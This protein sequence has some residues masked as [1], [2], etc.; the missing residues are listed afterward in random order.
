VEGFCKII[1]KEVK[2]KKIFFLL[3]LLIC[4]SSVYSELN[5]IRLY[6]NTTYIS[7]VKTYKFNDRIYFDSSDI[8]NKM[9]GKTYWYPVSQKLIIQLKSHKIAIDKKNDYIKFDEEEEENLPNIIIVRAGKVFVSRDFF[10]SKLFSKTVGF[11]IESD[12]KENIIRMIDNV[13]ITSMRYFSYKEKTRFVIYLDVPLEF[14]TSQIEKKNFIISVINGSYSSMNEKISINDGVINT[15]EFEQED[16]SARFLVNLGEN[17]K[18]VEVFTLKEPDRIVVDFK[19]E[20]DKLFN[21]IGEEPV[22][23]I[24]PTASS[25]TVAMST[26]V[27]VLPDK[28][29]ISNGN[30]KKIVIDPGHGGK[31]PG[32]KIIFGMKEKDIN[33]NVARELYSLLKKEEKFDVILTRNKDEFIALNERSKIANDF[34]ADIFVSIHAN[35]SKNKGEKGFEVYFLSEKATDPWS[36]EV[37]DYENAV[38]SF[39]NNN[40]DYSP[41]A[42]LLHSLARNEYINEG[43]KIA[44]YISKEYEKNTSFVN[45]GIKQ[46]AFYVLRGTYA[47]GILIEMGFMTNSQDQKKLSDR[48]IHKKIAKA[49]YEGI[50][51]YAK[52]KGW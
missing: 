13:N 21:R 11:R 8:I 25:Q 17:F 38:I 36:A 35:A 9:G 4:I 45:R 30:V 46:A 24:L 43:S 2:M 19:A 40:F 6:K 3:S 33:L 41:A 23:L 32:G 47:P 52:S 50:L 7:K 22:N 29:G 14:K 20:E 34:G 49:I 44:G 5:E 27:A 51:K 48:K 39:E 37:A 26:I 16:K 31:D 1:L 10:L 42:I 15:V 12:E 28:I 18:D